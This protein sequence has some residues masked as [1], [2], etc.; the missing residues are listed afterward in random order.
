MKFFTQRLQRSLKVKIFVMLLVAVVF[1]EFVY[2]QP[3]RGDME[4]TRGDEVPG[5]LSRR[6]RLRSHARQQ[7][8]CRRFC[9][10]AGI[11][12]SGVL[13]TWGVVWSV[14]VL[15]QIAEIVPCGVSFPWEVE[16]LNSLWFIG[17]FGYLR[18]SADEESPLS[19]DQDLA[20]ISR[21]IDDEAINAWYAPHQTY[22]PGQ[23]GRKPIAAASKLRAHL[24][25]ALK[26]IASFNETC[27]Q[28]KRNTV[29]QAFCGV[30]SISA[31]TLSTFRASLTFDDLITLMKIFIR[32]ADDL[33]FFDECADLYVQDSTDLE[34]PCSWHVIETITRG[35]Q[36]IK[37]YRDPTARVGKRAQK[38]GKSPF[39]VGHRKHTLGVIRG[40]KVIPLLSV[41]L[42][43]DRPDQYVLLPLLHLAGMVGLEVRYLVVDLAYIDQK[44]KQVALKRYGVLVSTDKKVNTTLPEQTDPKTGQPQCFQGENMRWDGFDPTTGQHTYLCPLDCPH[45]D[46]HYAPLCPGE[47]TIDADAYPIAFRLLPVHTEP[48]REM[49]KKRKAVEPMFRRERQHGALDNVT[50]MGNA[51]VHVLACLADLCDLLKTLAQLQLP[52]TNTET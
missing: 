31:G 48:V 19:C 37:V 11:S 22:Q 47:R 18:S 15:S 23:K 29:Y 35:K 27:K 24:L 38:K 51:N 44:R 16:A 32:K 20:E 3:C 45:H 40:T 43:A 14:R 41:V 42:P 49:L 12:V 8:W 21:L 39:F 36:T 1:N 52:M 25:F 9:W 4:F 2:S 5:R 30:K 26:Q 13:G 17:V 28:I 7:R 50:L 6:Q 10:A 34:S 33:G 46:C